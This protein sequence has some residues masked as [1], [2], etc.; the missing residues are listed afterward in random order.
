[1]TLSFA[2]ADPSAPAR[3]RQFS[4]A[5]RGELIK[6]LT[7]RGLPTAFA[8]AAAVAAAT[9]AA[10]ASLARAATEADG[11]PLNDAWGSTALT[12]TTIPLL[13]AW[14]STIILGELRT[15]VLRETFRVLPARGIVLASKVTVAV[16]CTVAMTLALIPICHLIYAAVARRSSAI[17]YLVSAEGFVNAGKL[18]LIVAC[19]TVITI[20]LAAIVRSMPLT[21]GLLLVQYLFLEAYLVEIP[22]MEWLVYVL[23]FSSGKG[24]LG[25][26]SVDVQIESGWLGGIGQLAVSGALFCL[27]LMVTKRRDL[28]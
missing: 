19:W 4:R 24:F 10:L 21:I 6:V 22:R 2:T 26:L 14:A 20:S 7:T 8:A 5:L 1:M 12:L 15:G 27:A 11:Q 17:G 16:I 18:S 28:K 23:P 25:E 9:T 13:L 3:S